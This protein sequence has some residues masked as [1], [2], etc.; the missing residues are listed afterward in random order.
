[1]CLTTITSGRA[2]PQNSERANGQTNQQKSTKTAW[3]HKIYLREASEYQFF[4]DE[5]KR[6]ALE[7]RREPIMRWTSDNEYHGE[8]FVWTHHGAAAILGCIVSGPQGQIKR[9][10]MHEFHSLVPHPLYAG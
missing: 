1:V 8:I 6:T 5:G 10:I 9:A 2:W 3:L 4:L 7:L